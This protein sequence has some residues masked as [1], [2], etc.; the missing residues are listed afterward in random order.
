MR[1]ALCVIVCC[2]VTVNMGT[3]S[4]LNGKTYIRVCH[5]RNVNLR[6]RA[7]SGTHAPHALTR[8][9]TGCLAYSDGRQR[10]TVLLDNG[11]R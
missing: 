3:L 4:W 8:E 2:Y 6:S 5:A 9:D 7:H 10:R 1:H 11:G